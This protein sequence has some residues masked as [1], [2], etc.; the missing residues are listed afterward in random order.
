MSWP[1]RLGERVEEATVR[2]VSLC[3]CDGVHVYVDAE[4]TA[5][6]AVECQR[7]G[8]TCI[9]IVDDVYHSDLC[10]CTVQLLHPIW[11]TISYISRPS[12]V[13]LVFPSQFNK[14]DARRAPISHG[15]GYS[16]AAALGCIETTR[17]PKISTRMQSRER[18]HWNWQTANTTL[19]TAAMLVVLGQFGR[20]VATAVDQLA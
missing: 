18:H 3:V 12:A 7:G 15:E 16:P 9:V 20:R 11:C 5:V 2:V 19:S 1:S 10:C 13:L 14:R 4:K 8:C 6:W 17:S